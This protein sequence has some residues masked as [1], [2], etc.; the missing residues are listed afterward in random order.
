MKM[1]KLNI[2]VAS[3][4]IIG[5]VILSYYI[6]NS[7]EKYGGSNT[8]QAILEQKP[9]FEEQRQGK[10][11]IKSSRVNIYEF[12]NLKVKGYPDYAFHISG[13]YYKDKRTRDLLLKLVAGDTLFLTISERDYKQKITKEDK[14]S[15]FQVNPGLIYVYGLKYKD[16]HY[17]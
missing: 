5:L 12:V 17:F 15:L 14:K 4:L 10:G 9:N 2:I 3:I 7:N 13:E 16:R 8:I 11:G 1:S 6:I